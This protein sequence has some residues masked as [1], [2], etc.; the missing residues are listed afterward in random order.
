M[1][2]SPGRPRYDQEDR[3]VATAFKKIGRKVVLDRDDTRPLWVQL[4]NQ[5]EEAINTG[6]VAANSRIPSEQALCELFGISRPVVRAALGALAT[7]GRVVKLPRKGMFVAPPRQQVDFISSNLGVFDDLTAKGHAVTTRTFEFFRCAPNE[8]ECKVFG[9]PREGSVVRIGRVYMSDGVPITLTHIS[10]PGHKVPG[11]ELLKIENKSVFQTIRAQYG[12]TVQRAERWFTAAL[13]TKEESE[14]M[15]VAVNTPLIAIESIA[16]DADG[17][18]LEYYEALYNSS[19]ARIHVAIDASAAAAS[20]NTVKP[21]QR[22]A[23][24]E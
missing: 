17:A 5:M 12:L 15:G 11:L 18:A 1:A 3:A 10:L 8:K 20:Q 16:Y 13:P 21:V 19:L 4:R 24:A 7:D 2:K 9:I 6:V 22:M 23:V 14:R